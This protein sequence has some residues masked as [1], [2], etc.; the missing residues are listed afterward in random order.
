MKKTRFLVAAGIALAMAFIFSCS[1]G[2]NDDGNPT[3]TYGSVTYDGKTY[4][5]VKIG[6]QT[7]MAQNLNYNANGSVCYDNLES[8]CAIY[9]R[10]YDWATAMTVCP[11]G[12]HLPSNAEWDQL[13]R[14]ADGTNGTSSPYDSP[15]AG[16]KLKA[17]SGWN[18]GGNGTDDFGFAALPG[19]G[20]FS[21]DDFSGAGYAGRW[22][23][24]SEVGRGGAYFRR[25]YYD[26]KD[27]YWDWD[28]YDGKSDLFSVR[29][30][31]D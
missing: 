19:G 13:S 25:M 10:L 1:S 3:Y 6:N 15:T 18:E 2:D 14:F 9:G 26:I 7:W 16:G 27:A 4:N 11:S 21:R 23:S 5:T 20:G 29:C 30:V 12:W 31:Q 22:W 24:A 8:N 28:D 17:I